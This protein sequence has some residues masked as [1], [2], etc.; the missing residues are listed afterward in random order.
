MPIYVQIG[1]S[2]W[3]EVMHCLVTGGAGFIGSNIAAELVRQGHRVTVLDDFSTGRE[4]NI[5][6]IWDDLSIIRGDITDFETVRRAVRG[7][8]YVFHHAAI[9]SV[10]RS[11]L[12]PL[13]SSEVNIGGTL[14]LLEASRMEEVKAFVLASSAAVYGNEPTLPKAESSPIELLSPYAASKAT[15]EHYCRLYFDLYGLKTVALRYFNVFGP[16]QNPMSEYAAVV[17]RFVNAMLAG[18]RPIIFGD[19]LQSRDFVFVD[20]VVAAN[21]LAA[22]SD[23][24]AGETFNVASGKN[25][26]LLDL[27]AALGQVMDIDIEPRFEGEKPGDIRHSLADVSKATELLGFDATANFEEGLGRTVEYFRMRNREKAWSK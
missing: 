19:G 18:Q 25:Y 16:N 8:K 24:A 20:R 7:V 23:V 21:L 12:D 15:C 5:L 2:P 26:A 4:E 13:G 1:E 11:I 27:L 22:E 10:E 6:P 9:A 17:P 3:R 14:N